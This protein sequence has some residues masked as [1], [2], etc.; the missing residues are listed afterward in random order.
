MRRT[1]FAVLV[2][3]F[4]IP[5]TLRAQE[6]ELATYTPQQRWERAARHATLGRRGRYCLREDHG[7]VGGSLC[8]SHGGSLRPFLG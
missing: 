7:P 4:L 5:L 2:L 1:V 8:R 3:L 6:I